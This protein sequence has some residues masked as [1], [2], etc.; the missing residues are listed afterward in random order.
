MLSNATYANTAD[1]LVAAIRQQHKEGSDFVKIY[2]TGADTWRRALHSPYQYTVAQL[3]AAVEAT[4]G[5]AAG[6]R[7]MPRS[8]RTPYAARAGV[9]SY[10]ATQLSDE[11]IRIMKAKNI[12]AVPTF[13]ILNIS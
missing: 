9:A 6:L 11:T 12:P 10:H 13:A 8:A 3:K 4:R 7:S 1:E 5:S 2:E